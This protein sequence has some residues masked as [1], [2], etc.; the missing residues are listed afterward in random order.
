LV[1]GLVP[2]NK[3]E[4]LAVEHQS[5]WKLTTKTMQLGREHWHSF[6]LSGIFLSEKIIAKVQR[7]RMPECST[8]PTRTKRR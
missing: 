4:L 1:F 5:L 2:H 7:A 6:F 8:R 3:P